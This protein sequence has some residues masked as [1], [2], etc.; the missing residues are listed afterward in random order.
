M[1]CL[2]LWAFIEEKVRN[3]MLLTVDGWIEAE[4]RMGVREWD[5]K[6]VMDMLSFVVDN[7]YWKRGMK[8]KRQVKGFGMGLQCAPQMANLACYVT[9]REF[10]CRCKPEE[11]QFNYR[12]IDDILTMSGQDTQ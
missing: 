8:L 2:K 10:A 4:G 3:R 6:E 1:R 11:V 7:G 5:R 9:E 12:F